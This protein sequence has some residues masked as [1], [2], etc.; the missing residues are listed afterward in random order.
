MKHKETSLLVGISH[1]SK[2]M[3]SWWHHIFSTPV[4]NHVANPLLWV[5]KS[6]RELV[7]GARAEVWVL[8]FRNLSLILVPGFLWPEP[9]VKA[10]HDLLAHLAGFFPPLTPGCHHCQPIRQAGSHLGW[11]TLVSW[12]FSKPGTRIILS[13]PPIPRRL[14]RYMRLSNS[15]IAAITNAIIII[16]IAGCGFCG[17]P[18]R[19][20]L[21]AFSIIGRTGPGHAWVYIWS[22]R[23]LRGS[24][25]PCTQ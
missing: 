10:P 9:T 21:R 22:G 8:Q 23:D 16:I 12:L 5:V 11:F 18:I 25:F 15:C 1:H 17:I 3:L 6:V 19:G 4:T 7:I 24:R 13:T 14:W 2:L 20:C